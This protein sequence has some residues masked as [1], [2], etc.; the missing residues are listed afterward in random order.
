MAADLAA[1]YVI[2]DSFLLTR[3]GA[4]SHAAHFIR[5]ANLII[6]EQCAFHP[7]RMKV[8]LGTFEGRVVRCAAI[9]S[10]VEDPVPG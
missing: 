10:Y 9:T 2:P 3:R 5:A 1:L 6:L 4:L 7:E 8:R